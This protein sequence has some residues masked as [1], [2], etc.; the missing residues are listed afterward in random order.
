MA[1]DLSNLAQLLQATN[2][3]AEAEPLM[4][5]ALAIDE[6]SF[7]PDHP[8]VA[9]ALNNLAPLLQ[10]TNRLAEAEPLMRRALAIDEKSFGPDHPNVAIASTIWHAASDTNRL[11]RPSLYRR[12][13]A[14]YEKSLA[15]SSRCGNGLNNLAE[16]L[17]ATNRLAEA[18]P[19][20]RRALAIDE[21]SFGPDH[22][23]VATDLNNLA[24]AA[25]GHEP[26]RRGRALDAPR[27][28]DRREKLRPRSSQC[29]Q[30]PQ[31]SGGA[32][33]G[34][35][36]LPRPSRLSPRAR[37][38][39][40]ELRPRSSRCG[41]DLNNLAQLLQATNRLAEA[42]PLMRRALA[43]DEKSFGP[44]HPNVA[45]DLNNLAL[46][47]QNT[48][49]LAEAEPLIA[50]R[51]PSDEKSLGPD[52]PDVATA[53]NNLALLLQATNRLAE[54]EPLDAPRGRDRRGELRPRSS[55]CG[56]APE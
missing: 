15:R 21:K 44:D 20:M 33:S 2:R 24:T 7:G 6:K 55:Q 19:L 46:L 43:I 42:E 47:L 49:R 13:L 10:A 5:R 3:L 26:A 41:H 32:A 45:T 14:I 36:G 38:R 39:R 35:T 22:P 48:N 40:E 37:D 8:N 29:G 27:A 17:K 18:E 52:H 16:L 25:S 4:R 9:R 56:H 31:Q 53:L 1:T 50:A 30:R 23:N 28:R 54:A 51:W 12:A 34:P 11:P